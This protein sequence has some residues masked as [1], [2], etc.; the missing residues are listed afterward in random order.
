[1]IITQSG[2]LNFIL[3]SFDRSARQRRLVCPHYRT[4]NDVWRF[5]PRTRGNSTPKDKQSDRETF[6][7]AEEE[8]MK[9]CFF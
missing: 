6:Y 1:M 9:M 7:E 3:G 2:N 5:C 8:W 4:K